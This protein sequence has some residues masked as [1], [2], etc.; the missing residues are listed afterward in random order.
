[1]PES[2]P[3]AAEE[4]VAIIG[5]ALP[6]P[7][8]LPILAFGLFL[9]DQAHLRA[10]A[11]T[12]TSLLSLVPVLAF[13]FSM[14]RGLG[15]EENLLTY[16]ILQYFPATDQGLHEK[17]L[18]YVRQVNA[19]TLGVAGLAG[20][21]F[22]VWLTL[23][24]VERALNATFG[25]RRER[26]WVRKVTDYFAIL[27]LSPL[28]IAIIMSGITVL[29]VRE[30][31]GG[32]WLLS[33]AL[34]LALRLVPILGAI[35]LFS[36][37]II[38]MPNTQVSPRAAAWG[39]VVGGAIWFFLQWGYVRFQVGF[40]RNEAIYGALA[41]LPVFMA[42]VYLSWCALLYAAALAALAEGRRP[43]PEP[44]EA[45][46][47]TDPRELALHILTEAA[48]RLAKAQPPLA[49][50]DA[51]RGLDVQPEILE[52]VLDQLQT[53]GYLTETREGG[54]FM[55]TVHP[56]SIRAVEAWDLFT[57]PQPHCSPG[58]EMVIQEMRRRERSALEGLTLEDLRLAPE[59][60]RE[61][62]KPAPRA[63]APAE[64]PA[65][66]PEG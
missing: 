38:V 11:L 18:T 60:T 63:A 7:L 35:L 55:L 31:L 1:M 27:F 8:R 50:E 16:L 3:R 23:G 49:R 24:T 56:A 57:P 52:T 59:K 32:I 65:A 45:R 43:P 14:L 20:L 10:A 29:Q 53:R 62:D 58:A 9:S 17:L 13:A 30:T 48:V 36:W 5:R 47:P 12:Y 19:G 42:W 21:L 22:S 46:H 34:E 2:R 26:T 37:I 4:H 51:R 64:E 39:G 33:E 61:D 41:Q 25:A 40:A 28:M 54:R 15:F 44:G 6:H 66:G